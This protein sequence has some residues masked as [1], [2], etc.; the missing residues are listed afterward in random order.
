MKSNSKK[1]VFLIVLA[2][3]FV[4]LPNFMLDFDR[5]QKTNVIT[6]KESAGYLAKFIHVNGNWSATTSYGWCS[7]DG[8]WSNPYTIEN[9]T[10]DASSSPTGSGIFINNSKND[11]FIIRNCT[12]YNAGS[13]QYDGGIKLENT[14]NGT[15]TNN[16]CSNNARDGIILINN[17]ENN[18]I[19]GNIVDNNYTGI[20]LKDECNNNIISGNTANDDITG[21]TLNDCNNNTLSGNT[22]C[23]SSSNGIY[24][25]NTC[26]NNTILGNTV[27][28]NEIGMYFYNCNYNIITENT[29]NDNIDNTGIVLDGCNNNI[30]SENIAS[31]NT[32]TGIIL[33]NSCNNNTISG[34]ILSDNKYGINIGNSINNIIYGNFFLANEIHAMDNGT[35][36]KWNSMT[37]GNYWD[38]HT[39]PDTT[40]QDGIVDVS[41]TH[42][43]GSA[44]SIDY[45]PIAEDGAPRITIHAPS[46][47]SSF[48]SVAP[49]FNIEVIDDF[50]FEM[51]YTIDGGLNNYTFTENGTI[52]QSAWDA[53]GEGS[54]TITFYAND[55]VG[56]EAFEE[57]TLTKS[58]SEEGPDPGGIVIIV[59]ISIVGGVA[60]IS[61]LY[62]FM[63]KRATPE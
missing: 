32:Y 54:V 36:N 45:L 24:L 44:G 43:G 15:L 18:T 16:N 41:Y 52:D 33:I 34:N 37:I 31:N 12:V 5:G 25:S 49:F 48:S 51:W 10:I 23:N 50:L 1:I 60:V 42:I 11:Y 53:L 19:S 27:N 62:I 39:G 56:N 30:I 59:V 13:G 46:A 40:P 26:T 20:F 8:S 3:G 7:G 2:M 58:F 17:C 47:G 29:V 38:N 57:V 14:N 4:F 21:I 6:P 9:V 61:G 55:I 35:D 63:K 28:D 22:A